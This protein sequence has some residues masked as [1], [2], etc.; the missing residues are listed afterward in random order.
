[1]FSPSRP[2][3]SSMS[4]AVLTIRSRVS[5]VRAMQG[6]Y[7]T[8]GALEHRSKTGRP[9]CK[10]AAIL[11]LVRCASPSNRHGGPG[12]PNEREPRGIGMSSDVLSDFVDATAT[13]FGVPGAAAG[14]L[15]EGEE[16]FAC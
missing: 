13:R 3:A 14:V 5:L 12:A 10:G 4:I 2:S 7:A 16:A 11:A 15:A 1:M 8:A 6:P 9:A